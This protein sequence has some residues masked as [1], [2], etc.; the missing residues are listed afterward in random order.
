MA[1]QFTVKILSS[2]DFDQLPFRRIQENPSDIMGA[3]N[4]KTRTAY[5][6][7]TGFNDLTKDIISHELDEL[8]AEESPHED[9]DGIRYFSL[10]GLFS[11]IG[12]GISN[13]FNFG[14]SAVGALGRGIKNVLTP[15]PA[16]ALPGFGTGAGS[17]AGPVFGPLTQGQTAIKSGIDAASSARG[18][19]DVIS[20]GIEGASAA[21]AARGALPGFNPGTVANAGGGGFGD[22][23][24]S[25]FGGGGP[26]GQPTGGGGPRIQAGKTQI[27]GG[28]GS[29]GGFDLGSQ[30]KSAAPGALVSLLGNLFAPKVEA[31]DF[32]GISEGLRS[33]IGGE[34]GGSPA[35]NLGF[36]EAERQLEGE[37]GTI[38]P[39]VLAEIDLRRDEEIEALTN[40][41]R[42]GQG[43]GA[44][45]ESDTSRF[46][47]LRN[48]IVKKFEALKQQTEFAYQNAQE[49]RRVQ[50]MTTALNLDRAQFEQY[51]QLANL[52]IDEL[53][54]K[55]GIDAKTATQFKT[56]FGNIGGK[57]IDNALDAQT[58]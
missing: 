28:D 16:P 35:F 40:R 5:I 1:E 9:E 57:L 55:T 26:S 48:D 46:G 47:T 19:G 44:I 8:M 10:S 52:Q 30:L 41:F 54:I 34:D 42:S 17:T 22:F 53:M 38:P 27:G 12:G 29:V 58:A 20:R 14:K 39:A 56:L 33:R 50:V 25:L 15:G 11:G 3:S 13:L 32:S 49:D 37:P 24:S 21:S 45:S 6:R 43:G 31:P 18:F 36:G 7:D 4:P 23:I 2:E 51:T